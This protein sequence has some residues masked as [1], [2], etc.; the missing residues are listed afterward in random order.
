MIF[1]KKNLTQENG[2]SIINETAGPTEC[3]PSTL[4][5]KLTEYLKPPKKYFYI[6]RK[7]GHKVP[8]GLEE[9]EGGN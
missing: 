4:Y 3:E 1:L 2:Q 9:H 8:G 7:I 5:S 6:Y